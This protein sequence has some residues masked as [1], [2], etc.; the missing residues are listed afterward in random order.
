MA[1][2]P[3]PP[4]PNLPPSETAG[5]LNHWFPFIRPAI[6]P[7]I[8]GAAYIRGDWLIRPNN[9]V[10]PPIVCNR[11]RF[12][13]NFFDLPQKFI[14]PQSQIWTKLSPTLLK[15]MSQQN[16]THENWKSHR[17]N[18]IPVLVDFI[19]PTNKG[20]KIHYMIQPTSFFST[21]NWFQSYLGNFLFQITSGRNTPSE[22]RSLQKTTTRKFKVALNLPQFHQTKTTSWQKCPPPPYFD[23]NQHN[24]DTSFIFLSVNIHHF[25]QTFPIWFCVCLF[26]ITLPETNKSP[27]KI[28]GWKIKFPFG[29]WAYFQRYFSARV[30][31]SKNP[32]QRPQT[33]VSPGAT[34][35]VMSK[36]KPTAPSWKSLGAR[37]EVINK[38]S[39]NAEHFSYQCMLSFFLSASREMANASRRKCQVFFMSMWYF[40]S[41]CAFAVFGAE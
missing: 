40:P 10:A 18:R 33:S 24:M 37:V 11:G 38:S 27:L 26:Y 41:K 1:G 9:L 28:N 3:G 17:N 22:C 14:K 12:R 7:L 5:L 6:E 36:V 21:L 32:L 29:A 4:P 39:E 25:H 15:H 13:L 16:K 19:I 2:P 20:S 31:S 34:E 30:F 23:E 8:R 35:E